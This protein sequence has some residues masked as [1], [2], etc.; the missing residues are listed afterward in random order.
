[1]EHPACKDNNP[2]KSEDN[3]NDAQEMSRSKVPKYI[4]RLK[5]PTKDEIKSNKAPMN[6]QKSDA[7]KTKTMKHNPRYPDYS[8]H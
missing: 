2:I 5:M 6:F 8:K 7:R 4:K 3:R 1:M